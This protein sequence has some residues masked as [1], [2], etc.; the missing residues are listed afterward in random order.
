M[1]RILRQVNWNNF[2]IFVSQTYAGRMLSC[3]DLQKFSKTPN[4][5]NEAFYIT[6]S[7]LSYQP[8]KINYMVIGRVAYAYLLQDKTPAYFFSIDDFHW[9]VE[10]REKNDL[11]KKHL[12]CLSSLHHNRTF[13]SINIWDV[14]EDELVENL[15]FKLDLGNLEHMFE[16]FVFKHVG[17]FLAISKRIWKRKSFSVRFIKINLFILNFIFQSNNFFKTHLVAKAKAEFLAVKT[18]Q[19]L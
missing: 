4:F 13:G 12:A 15:C 10:L 6:I 11:R 8:N 3:T 2:G 16:C 5:D 17:H 9:V 18:R 1:F 7:V 19:I 14:Y